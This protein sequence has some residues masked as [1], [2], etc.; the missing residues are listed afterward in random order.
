MRLCFWVLRVML[1]LSFAGITHPASHFSLC[2]GVLS[3][4]YQRWPMPASLCWRFY[5][6]TRWAVLEQSNYG[7][8]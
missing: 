3:I 1:V 7:V 2:D 4:L 5:E 8:Q 6:Y